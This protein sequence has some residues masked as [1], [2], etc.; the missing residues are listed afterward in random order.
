VVAVGVGG[1][2]IG[3]FGLADADYYIQGG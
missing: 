3:S 2:K 1:G